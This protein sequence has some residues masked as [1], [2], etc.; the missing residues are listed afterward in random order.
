[1]SPQPVIGVDAG[2]TKLLAGALTDGTEVHQRVYR[3]WGG[4]DRD[5]VL[6]TMVEAGDEVPAALPGVG[7]GGVRIPSPVGAGSGGSVFR[8]PPPPAGGPF[9]GLMRALLGLPPF[10]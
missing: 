3:R 6:A 5:E 4:G 10:L 2:G 1:M 8:G 9:R 7:A